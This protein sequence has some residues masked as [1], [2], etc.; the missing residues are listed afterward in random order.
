M[1]AGRNRVGT[2]KGMGHR[3]GVGGKERGGFGADGAAFG[4]YSATWRIRAALRGRGA[5]GLCGTAVCG[6]GYGAP[7]GGRGGEDLGTSG[8]APEGVWGWSHW[9]PPA[10]AW[11]LRSPCSRSA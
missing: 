1:F 4:G 7:G 9:C 6:V 8:S 3:D 2:G 5:G 11:H 10:P